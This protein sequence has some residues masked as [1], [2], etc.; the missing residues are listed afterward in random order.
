[1]T[2]KLTMA[3]IVIDKEPLI[4]NGRELTEN[5]KLK[6]ADWA[7]SAQEYFRLSKLYGDPLLIPKEDL[8]RIHTLALSENKAPPLPAPSKAEPKTLNGELD[9]ELLW[10]HYP[11]RPIENEGYLPGIATA[12]RLIRTQEDFDQVLKIIKNYAR[13]FK[14]NREKAI[15]VKRFDRFL[16]A[17]P[18]FGFNVPPAPSSSPPANER[19]MLQ[20]PWARPN[21]PFYPWEPSPHDPPDVRAQKLQLANTLTA[22][23]KKKIEE[24]LKQKDGYYDQTNMKWW[25]SY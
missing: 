2:K 19:R 1:M 7:P 5:E 11:R 18:E 15:Y 9:Y 10:K 20:R 25:Y 23:E 24:E 4:P 17:L 16:E 3:D 21:R 14:N 13:Q 22:A 12:K 8:E 6:I